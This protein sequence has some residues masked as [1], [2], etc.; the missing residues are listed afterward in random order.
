[1]KTE[2]EKFFLL[3]S[4]GDPT[5]MNLYEKREPKERNETSEDL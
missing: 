5:K 2:E 3:V 1:M 4:E